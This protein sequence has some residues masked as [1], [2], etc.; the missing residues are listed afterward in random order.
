M[1]VGSWRLRINP[2]ALGGLTL[3]RRPGLYRDLKTDSSS[4]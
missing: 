4:G 2:E 3:N 1:I